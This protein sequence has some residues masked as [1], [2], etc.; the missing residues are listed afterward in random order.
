[1]PTYQSNAE[2]TKKYQFP[3]CEDVLE[4]Y[5]V[6]GDTEVRAKGRPASKYSQRS[7]Q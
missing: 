7:A 1:M 2:F 3:G 6:L 5:M 4:T